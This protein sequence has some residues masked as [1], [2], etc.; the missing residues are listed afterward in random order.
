MKNF[1]IIIP[2]F[3]EVES[4][5]D[6]LDEIKSEFSSY[7]FEIVLV[8]DGS[9]DNFQSLCK[10][11]N[12]N[13]KI[14]KHKRNLGKCMAMLSGV[15]ASTNNLIGV[16]D[17]DGQNPPSELKKMIRFW[18]DIPSNEKEFALLCGNR[19]KRKDT[20]IKRLSSKIANKFRKFIL[21]DDCND[22]ACA[23]KVFSKS[24]F[25]K[26]PY[27]TNMH[28]FLPALFK[29]KNG[30]IFNITVK[31]RERR[32]GESKY[33]FHNRFWVGI[34]DLLIVWFIINFKKGETN[35]S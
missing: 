33:N 22:T 8:D 14:I 9:S 5:F 20:L 26:I 6:V 24:D 7:N 2:I 30:K 16:M 4:I 25:L 11:L 21:N 32:K 27:I 34:K 13:I 3:N 1:T 35:D 28:R 31:D 12:D 10:S 18:I 23:L 19:I 15:K 17:G 29:M